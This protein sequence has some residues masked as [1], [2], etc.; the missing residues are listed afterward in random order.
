MCFK[1]VMVRSS[2]RTQRLVLRVSLDNLQCRNLGR[3]LNP[4]GTPRPLRRYGRFHVRLGRTTLSNVVLGLDAVCSSHGGS[5]YRSFCL[6]SRNDP[7]I[8][9]QL[10]L[11]EWYPR[12][13][14]RQHTTLPSTAVDLFCFPIHGQST[15]G[16]TYLDY[17]LTS[18]PWNQLWEYGPLSDPALSRPLH[19]AE[20][21]SSF[22]DGFDSRH[23]HA[24]RNI[25]ITENMPNGLGCIARCFD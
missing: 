22:T 7:S 10:M 24:S 2:S 4:T 18:S 13:E 15:R 23:G 25:P 1:P 3:S 14:I 11:L 8:A 16:G 12:L 5:S 17:P 19:F 20:T 9:T 21:A 6:G